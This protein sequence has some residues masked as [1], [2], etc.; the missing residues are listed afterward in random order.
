MNTIQRLAAGILLILVV[1]GCGSP[2]P[3]SYGSED[4]KKIA[5]LIEDLNEKK[6]NTVES[7][8]L[9]VS[10][11]ANLVRLGQFS[12]DVKGSPSVTGTTATAT[13]AVR[14]EGGEDKG[15]QQWTFEKVGEN[16]R[17]KTAPLP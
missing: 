5:L 9:F 7:K 3:P 12:F 17:I 1:Q 13:L 15:Q 6:G 4:G 11:P 8:K 10:V 2:A 14:T 16:W